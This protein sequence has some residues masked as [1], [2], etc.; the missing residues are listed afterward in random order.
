VEFLIFSLGCL[1]AALYFF[2]KPAWVRRRRQRIMEQPFPAAWTSILKAHFPLFNGLTPG[3]QQQLQGKILVF[4]AEK[5][6]VGRQGQEVTDEVRVLTAAQACLLLLNRETNFFPRLTTIYIYP[7]AYLA[8][9]VTRSGHL[10]SETTQTN[11]GESWDS[12]ELVLA[13]DA[14]FHGARN[15]HDGRNVVFHEFAH[16]L[17]QE[18]GTADGAPTLAEYSAYASWARVLGKEYKILIRRKKKHRKTVLDK[19]GATHP[20]EFFAVASEAFFEKPRQ[21]EK[22]HPELYAELK[23]YYATDP[24]EWYDRIHA[25]VTS[26]GE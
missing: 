4:L 13:W 9:R 15:T 8:R 11:L 24:V 21:L 25:A 3:L 17:D 14:A 5:N 1:L 18:D 16:Q 19:Y 26:G 10:V 12:G 6:F 23:S 22:R 2:F 7:T 20:A